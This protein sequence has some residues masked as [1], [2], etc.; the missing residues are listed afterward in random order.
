MTSVRL[1]GIARCI[2]KRNIEGESFCLFNNYYWA[3]TMCQVLYLPCALWSLHTDLISSLQLCEWGTNIVY[4]LQM[5]VSRA[6][7]INIPQL[8]NNSCY[9]FTSWLDKTNICLHFSKAYGL[10]PT[11][12]P[13][14]CFSLTRCFT[15]FPKF[16]KYSG[17][18]HP[19]NSNP[20]A[21]PWYFQLYWK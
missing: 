6:R 21:F 14:N 5:R 16:H 18:T 13:A 8:V 1:R 10:N 12:T 9:Y 11:K 7:R 3:S 15:D 4:L 20:L 19:H 17:C 2:N